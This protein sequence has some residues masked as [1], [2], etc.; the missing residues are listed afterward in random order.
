[1]IAQH[2]AMEAKAEYEMR[3]SITHNV[4]MMDPVLKA[5]HGAGQTAATEPYVSSQHVRV[6]AHPVQTT[7]SAL[8]HGE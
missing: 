4:L 5:V 7:P 6:L 3:N 8:D 2:E 1:M